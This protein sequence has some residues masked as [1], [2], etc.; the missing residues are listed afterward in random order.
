MKSTLRP[1]VWIFPAFLLISPFCTAQKVSSGD[2]SVA[3][4][5]RPKY[6]N[7]KYAAVSYSE[8]Y[9]FDRTKNEMG[10][11]VVSAESHE[12]VQFIALNDIAS[13]KYFQVYN[14]FVELKKFHY[15]TRNGETWWPSHQ[16][17]VD[18]AMTDDNIFLDDNRVQFF[19]IDLSK[20]GQMAQV[21]TDKQ[22]DDTK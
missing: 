18:M 7:D 10:Q 2:L 19:D 9:T 12:S 1:I 21:E 5:L 11:P 14:K 15:S 3:Q 6:T 17:P 13:V 20:T 22:Y 8:E 4:S 16:K